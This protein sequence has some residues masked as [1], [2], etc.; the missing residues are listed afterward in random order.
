MQYPTSI[1]LKIMKNKNSI[2]FSI[3]ELLVVVA[4]IGILSA[5]GVVSYNGYVEQAKKNNQSWQNILYWLK[6]F[7]IQFANYFSRSIC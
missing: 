6:F 7:K 3:I 4:I 5:I 1:I 2:G